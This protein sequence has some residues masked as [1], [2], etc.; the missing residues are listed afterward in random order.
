MEVVNAV[1]TVPLLANMVEVAW[2]VSRAIFKCSIALL[3][4]IL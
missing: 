1:L 3:I 2:E 4:L